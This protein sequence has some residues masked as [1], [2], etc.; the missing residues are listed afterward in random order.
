[1]VMLDR[2]N[3]RVPEIGLMIRLRQVA[4]DIP[5][6]DR[7]DQLIVKN[8]EGND[9]LTKVIEFALDKPEQEKQKNALLQMARQLATTP[10]RQ[11]ELFNRLS[12]EAIQG[13]GDKVI[14]RVAQLRLGAPVKMV[15][16]TGAAAPVELECRVWKTGG[17]GVVQ[18][19]ELSTGTVYDLDVKKKVASYIKDPAATDP[20]LKYEAKEL[21]DIELEA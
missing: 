9:D 11:S 7:I 4:I 13:K 19:R 14:E 15:W 6:I 17:D 20:A 16:D 10:G 18:L 1:M 3:D 2:L 21:K 8:A 5:L 12:K